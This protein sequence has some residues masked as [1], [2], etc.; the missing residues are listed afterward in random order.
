MEVGHQEKKGASGAVAPSADAGD[1]S[2]LPAGDSATKEH[3]TFLV[4]VGHS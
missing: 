2:A 1:S 3:R 4:F